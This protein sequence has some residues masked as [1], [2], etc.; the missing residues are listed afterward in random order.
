[1][2]LLFVLLTTVGG[3]VIVLVMFCHSK[4]SISI[5][6]VTMTQLQV[7]TPVQLMAFTCS[8]EML[9]QVHISLDI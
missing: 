9:L 5:K 2:K 3:L 7:H 6:G 4:K 8:G 1:M